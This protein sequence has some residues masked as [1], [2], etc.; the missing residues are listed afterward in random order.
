MVGD[1]AWVSIDVGEEF[2]VAHML[3]SSGKEL[4][5]RRVEYDEAAISGS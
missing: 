2:H 1:K 4:L 5:F 3:D